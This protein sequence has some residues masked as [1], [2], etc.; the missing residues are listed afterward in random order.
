MSSPHAYWTLRLCVTNNEIN[1]G[2]REQLL[3][4]LFSPYLTLKKGVL[5]DAVKALN[6]KFNVCITCI[7]FLLIGGAESNKCQRTMF[8]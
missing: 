1:Q 2:R 6:L 7:P 4:F 3:D 5:Y 8:W